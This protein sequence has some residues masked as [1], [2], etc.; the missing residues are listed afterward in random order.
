MANAD[1]KTKRTSASVSDFIDAISD[2]SRRNDCRRLASLLK[3]A[4]KSEPRMWGANVVGCG[5]YHYKYESGRENDWFVI[6]FSPR[7]ANLT[8]YFM[9]GTERYKTILAK[10]GK[11]K[12]GKGCL[13]IKKL[14]DVNL[15]VLGELVSTSTK[16]LLQPKKQ[17]S[18]RTPGTKSIKKHGRA[19]R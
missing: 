2:E 10:L 11:H 9:T 6:G 12:T 1:L 14:D 8:L 4:T 16:D 3:K 17:K 13:Y 18:A 7:K 15:D 5:D 19:L